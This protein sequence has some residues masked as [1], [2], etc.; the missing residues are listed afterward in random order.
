MRAN[1]QPDRVAFREL[2]NDL[3]EHDSVTYVELDRRARRLG[4]RLS[5]QVGLG[6]RALL[7][8]P[9]AID[10]MAALF[11]CFY[12]GIV[13]VSGIPAYAPSTRSLRH[14]ARLQRLPVARPLGQDTAQERS[15]ML[16][17]V[18]PKLSTVSPALIP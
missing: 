17:R 1:E 2:R 6:D 3:S 7:L 9:N 18:W 5:R 10:Y 13:A 4:E 14:T 8:I 16:G 15:I 11:A 12:A